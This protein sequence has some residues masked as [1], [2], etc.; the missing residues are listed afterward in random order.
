MKLNTEM[1]IFAFQFKK[2]YS[3]YDLF[4]AKRKAGYYGKSQRFT[5][6][7]QTDSLLLNIRLTQVLCTNTD[8]EAD[9]TSPAITS[10]SINSNADNATSTS[11]TLAISATDNVGVT[12]Y[13]TSEN[14]TTPED[15]AS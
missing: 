1:K 9:K 14:S 12:G 10:I 13:Y 2:K 3:H 15:S 5:I 6:G 11:V 7:S 8:V 4:S